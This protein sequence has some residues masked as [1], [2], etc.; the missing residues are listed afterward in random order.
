M[1]DEW[2]RAIIER[3]A[4]DQRTPTVMQATVLEAVDN[5]DEQAIALARVHVDGNPPDMV[6]IVPIAVPAPLTEGQRVLV[7]FDPP[8][9]AYIIG[10]TTG[11]RGGSRP[12]ATRVIAASDSIAPDRMLCDYVCDGTDDHVQ[13]NAAIAD[14]ATS[15]GRGKVLLLEGTFAITTDEVT[16]PNGVILAGLGSA[17]TTIEAFGDGRSL[18]FTGS[19]GGTLEDVTLYVDSGIAGSLL[20]DEEGICRRVHFTTR[21]GV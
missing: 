6:N 19:P 21:G 8:S 17:A 20:G 16:L 10:L 11:P 12:Y 18:A 3:V 2:A 5:P 15:L 13:I 4:R 7:Q 9:G 14:C 1:N